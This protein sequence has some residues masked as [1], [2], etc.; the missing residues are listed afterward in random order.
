MQF[1]ERSRDK[2]SLDAF[3]VRD[4]V[5]EQREAQKQVQLRAAIEREREAAAER[6][7]ERRR[8]ADM[9]FYVESELRD[10]GVRTI[11]RDD[12]FKIMPEVRQAASKIYYGS[13]TEIMAKIVQRRLAPKQSRGM[14][15]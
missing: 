2:V 15:H 6:K 5:A 1:G 10:R 13:Q 8:S 7:A 11:S 9:A 4:L 14:R 12:I 3:S